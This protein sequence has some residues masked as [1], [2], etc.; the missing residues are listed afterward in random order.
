MINFYWCSWFFATLLAGLVSGFHLSAAF[1]LTPFLSWLTA[2]KKTQETFAAFNLSA[3]KTGAIWYV[4]LS[5]LQPLT[6]SVFFVVSIV[7]KRHIGL[8]IFVVT[9]SLLWLMTSIATGFREVE[10][11]VL[12]SQREIPDEIA[13]K[14]IT[15]NVPIHIFNG[16]VLLIG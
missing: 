14:Y 9:L 7:A 12:R 1:M 4:V 15:W 6:G 2:N 5:V 16:V 8:A 11:T 10:K 13:E 3:S